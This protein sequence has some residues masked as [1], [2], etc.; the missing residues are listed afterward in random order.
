M[1]L[2]LESHDLKEIEE[3]FKSGIPSGLT[4]YPAFIQRSSITDETALIQKISSLA[5]VIHIDAIGEKSETIVH[6]AHRLISIGNNSDSI[7]I[8]IPVSMEGIKACRILSR[9]GIKINIQS[10][11][12]LQQ[13]YVAMQAG[14]AY[15]SIPAGKLQDHGYDSSALLEQSIACAKKYDYPTKVMITAVRSAEHVRNA[16]NSGVHAI[17]LP[18]NILKGLTENDYS[19]QSNQ[20]FFES[21][22]FL[23]TL[24]K[25]V[26]REINPQV[27]LS[28]TI[29]DAVV[30]MSQGGLGAVAVLNEQTKVIGVFTDG[31]LRRLLQGDGKDIL[32]MKLSDLKFKQPISIEANAYLKDAAQIL[33]DKRIDNLLVMNNGELIGML[34]IQDL[35]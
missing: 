4:T 26:L 32:T 24:V 22:R 2:Y 14:A 20:Q 18:W 13:A 12:T 7:V 8:R 23:T 6:E 25:D 3:A 29:L 9:E 1:E 35:N 34:D 27:R 10:V 5:H 30:Q 11:F 15:V 16:I 17:A 33:K 28:D 21:N 31:D 19:N